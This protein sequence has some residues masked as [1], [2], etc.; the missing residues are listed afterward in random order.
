[1][2]TKELQTASR[3][4]RWNDTEPSPNESSPLF[5]KPR[6]QH[7]YKLHNAPLRDSNPADSRRNTAAAQLSRRWPSLETTENHS[8]AVSGVS[9]PQAPVLPPREAPRHLTRIPTGPRSPRPPRGAPLLQRGSWR[10]RGAQTRGGSLHC[11]VVGTGL[12]LTFPAHLFASLPSDLG[13]CLHRVGN[14]QSRSLQEDLNH[15]AL[16]VASSVF[17]ETFI[18]NLF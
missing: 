1:M 15:G 13:R 9:V 17:S 2:E 5:A 14:E 18:Y 16:V 12:P 8:R 11:R 4:Q 10:G 7:S 3:L 6:E